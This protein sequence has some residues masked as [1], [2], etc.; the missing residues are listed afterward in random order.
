MYTSVE[1]DVKKGWEK[2]WKTKIVL[3]NLTNNLG[4]VVPKKKYHLSGIAHLSYWRLDPD[5]VSH[6]IK[7][8]RDPSWWTITT[9]SVFSHIFAATTALC[10]LDDF[11]IFLVRVSDEIMGYEL[12]IPK[13]S[14]KTTLPNSL[15]SPGMLQ[16]KGVSTRFQYVSILSGFTSKAWTHGLA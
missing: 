10:N 3:G 9:S 8:A 14:Y 1:H 6:N 4:L 12:K 13:E 11:R 16:T 2:H 5:F 7:T 15:P